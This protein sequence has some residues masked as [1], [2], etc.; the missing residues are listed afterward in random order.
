M[1]AVESELNGC[2]L[3]LVEFLLQNC[4]KIIIQMLIEYVTYDKLRFYHITIRTLVAMTFRGVAELAPT[5]VS[6]IP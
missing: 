3:H 2:S 5:Y 6:C 4:P 1:L